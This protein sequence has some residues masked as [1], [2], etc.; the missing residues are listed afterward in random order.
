MANLV[1]FGNNGTTAST[2]TLTL[3]PGAAS[4]A[5][6]HK[7]IVLDAIYVSAG[8]TAGISAGTI[9]LQ[10]GGVGVGQPA[11]GVAAPATSVYQLNHIYPGGFVFP[12]A[13]DAAKT[14]VATGLTGATQTRV[15]V[16]YHY[17]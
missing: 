2:A 3:P 15:V 16:V 5:V 7:S 4:A 9:E 10:A 8:T 14:V 1:A 11:G 17:E 13:S 12:G 6:G